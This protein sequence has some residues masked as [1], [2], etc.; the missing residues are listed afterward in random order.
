MAYLK[1]I[2]RQKCGD[3]GKV[4]TEVLCNRF[5]EEVGYYCGTHGVRHLVRHQAWERENVERENSEGGLRR[6]LA[7][8]QPSR[9]HPREN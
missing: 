8:V 5:N 2:Y 3:C 9:Q 1:A 4:A 6:L 7:D